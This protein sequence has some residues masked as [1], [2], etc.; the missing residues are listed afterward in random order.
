M[1]KLQICDNFKLVLA[2]S[3]LG[4]SGA[5]EHIKKALGSIKDGRIS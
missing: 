5:T 4:T 2:S 1:F 3:G